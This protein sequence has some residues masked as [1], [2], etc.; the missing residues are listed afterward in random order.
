MLLLLVRVQEQN[1]AS[2]QVSHLVH[3]YND[4]RT[5][6]SASQPTRN[7]LT[8]PSEDPQAGTS[9]A[10][11]DTHQST[12]SR[13]PSGRS[14]AFVSQH[15]IA[16]TIHTAADQRTAKPGASTAARPI[17]GACTSPR[18]P[19]LDTRRRTLTKPST[20]CGSRTTRPLQGVRGERRKPSP[21]KR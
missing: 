21:A 2:V 13:T 7:A 12:N 20:R 17:G 4:Q 15:P 3:A 19:H 5:P 6:F 8:Y 11:N 9:P 16:T 1:G 14:A 18:Y 10:L